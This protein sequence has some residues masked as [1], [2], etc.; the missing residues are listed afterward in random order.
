MLSEVRWADYT[1]ESRLLHGSVQSHHET[2]A[3]TLSRVSVRSQ[4]T[5]RSS[6]VQHIVV[7]LGKP[8]SH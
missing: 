3:A 6:G 7:T 5:K 1:L 4:H 8:E 2:C